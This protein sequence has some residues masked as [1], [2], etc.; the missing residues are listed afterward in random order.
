LLSLNNHVAQSTHL[1]EEALLAL[2]AE[3]QRKLLDQLI[4]QFKKV[5]WILA[6]RLNPS[7][8]TYIRYAGAADQVYL[9]E[10]VSVLDQLAFKWGR[11]VTQSQL[12]ETGLRDAIIELDRLSDSIDEYPF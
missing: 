12:A 11:A 6:E 3:A 5:H 9:A 4:D 7:E 2:K 1:I 8:L 10:S